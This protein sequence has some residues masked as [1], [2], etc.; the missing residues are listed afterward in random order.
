MGKRSICSYSDSRRSRTFAF[1][2]CFLSAVSLAMTEW[3]HFRGLWCKCISNR[4]EFQCGAPD[5]PH[6]IAAA[7]LVCDMEGHRGFSTGGDMIFFIPAPTC[8]ETCEPDLEEG[9]NNKVYTYW[10]SISGTWE[11]HHGLWYKHTSTD[12]PFKLAYVSS[13]VA[14]EVARILCVLKG[15]RGFSYSGQNFFFF[16]CEICEYKC[17]DELEIIQSEHIYTY[18]RSASRSR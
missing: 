12:L 2:C 11:Y 14:D 10:K 18:M 4:S 17:E 9:R 1:V 7:Q 16:P 13:A 6:W 3:R 8:A 15:Y 5:D